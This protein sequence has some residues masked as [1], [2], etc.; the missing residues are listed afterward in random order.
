[1]HVILALLCTLFLC[2]PFLQ[3]IQTPEMG[4][5][6]RGKEPYTP[7]EGRSH[8]NHGKK[9]FKSHLLYNSDSAIKPGGCQETPGRKSPVYDPNP[10]R[11]YEWSKLKQVPPSN[12]P[13]GPMALPSQQLVQS[14][15]GS[16]PSGATPVYQNV[17]VKV[18]GC[19]P[20]SGCVRAVS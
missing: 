1:M 5:V 15:A 7:M 17:V 3:D 9:K 18:S 4:N 13:Q 2:R 6:L 16:G 8:G 11:C 12:P 19:V 20:N 10:P 14:H